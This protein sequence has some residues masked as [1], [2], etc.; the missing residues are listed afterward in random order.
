MVIR[1]S[2]SRVSFLYKREGIS[3]SELHSQLDNEHLLTAELGKLFCHV[4]ILQEHTFI[5]ISESYK[6]ALLV[7]RAYSASYKAYHFPLI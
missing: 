2:S 7:Q 3:F 4:N 5:K 6:E 1:H